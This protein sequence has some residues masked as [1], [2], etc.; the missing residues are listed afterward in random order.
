MG[1][2]FCCARSNLCVVAVQAVAILPYLCKGRY[3]IFYFHEEFCL[4]LRICLKRA[5][6]LAAIIPIVLSEKKKKHFSFIGLNSIHTRF[7]IKNL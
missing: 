5:I 1:K 7:P 2:V 3:S 6:F 4:E